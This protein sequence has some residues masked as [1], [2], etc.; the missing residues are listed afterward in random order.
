M[1]KAYTGRAQCIMPPNSLKKKMGSGG[2]D[3]SA[4][5]RAQSNLENN[6][7][8]FRPIAS[9]WLGVLEGAILGV[10]NG[11]VKNKAEV[12]IVLFPVVKL[13]EQ[14]SMFHFPLV[15]EASTVVSDILETAAK[16][17]KDIIDILMGYKMAILAIISHN[18]SG[19]GG[20]QGRELVASLTA[21]TGRYQ[22]LPV[23]K[24]I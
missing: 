13:K 12:D 21:A 6:T 10:K 7:I 8:D 4:L 19:D 11:H 3:E 17:D 24:S 18:M 1:A 22:N 5:A 20:E 15:T 23:S 9:R 2:I 16:V 14:G